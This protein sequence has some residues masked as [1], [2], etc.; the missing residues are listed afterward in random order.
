MRAADKV[1][2][3]DQAAR[4]EVVD[5]QHD[6]AEIHARDEPVVDEP[7]VDEPVV[8]EPVVDERVVEERV[9]DEPDAHAVVDA[10]GGDAAGDAPAV[11]GPVVSERAEPAPL[12]DESKNESDDEPG[13]DAVVETVATDD[14][15]AGDRVADDDA[16]ADAPRLDE[17]EHEFAEL[18]PAADAQGIRE[19]WREV[20]LRF[21][22][23][24]QAAAG[25]AATLVDD[26]SAVLITAIESRRTQLGAWRTNPPGDTE[27]LRLVVQRYREFVDRVLGV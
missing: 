6:D 16:V 18:W 5:D 8:D 20:Q 21:V 26:A 13:E 2:A 4:D 24:P 15:L 3:S 9:A 27:Q 17:A 11:E 1:A 25:E 7:V 22:D 14:T 10:S 19:R 23:D 12:H